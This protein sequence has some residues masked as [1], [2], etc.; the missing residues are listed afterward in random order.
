MR[1][2]DKEDDDDD[3]DRDRYGF[4]EEAEEWKR[5]KDGRKEAPLE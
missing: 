5:K 3:D 2:E 1:I 4:R